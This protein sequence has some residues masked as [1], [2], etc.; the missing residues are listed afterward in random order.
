MG[1]C[2]WVVH[3]QHIVN[4]EVLARSLEGDRSFCTCLGTGHII[5][6]NCTTLKKFR[7]VRISMTNLNQMFW[8]NI[9][10]WFA[11]S[12]PL[13]FK[14]VS[15]FSLQTRGYCWFTPPEE[16]AIFMQIFIF[17]LFCFTAYI[18]L[19]HFLNLQINSLL[20]KATCFRTINGH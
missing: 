4:P 3:I 18:I 5:H 20:G 1:T 16:V 19:C 9:L 2:W 17:E 11:N 7:Y 12:C 10:E 6:M 14:E 13:S 8:L 15:W